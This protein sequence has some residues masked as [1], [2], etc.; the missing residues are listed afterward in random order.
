MFHSLVTKIVDKLKEAKFSDIHRKQQSITKLFPAH[1]GRVEKVGHMGGVR[2]K[3]VLSETWKFSV[4]S[5][6]KK[7]VW[8]DG[9]IHWLN[10]LPTLEKLVKDH[11]LWNIEGTRVDLRLL[12]GAFRNDCEVQIECNCPCQQYWGFN[13]ILSTDR[14]KAKYGDRETRSP[15]KRN[16]HQY[17]AMCKHLEAL[18]KTMPF[19]NSTIARWLNDFYGKD[20]E[21]IEAKARTEAEKFKKAGEELGK[22]S[23]PKKEQPKEAP[24]VEPEKPESK[25]TAPE[26]EEE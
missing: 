23:Q 24:K 14:Y 3:K 20:I 7:S 6:T 19:Y 22:K 10:I 5:G 13:Y 16:P 15:S 17:G 18:F 2:I 26:P 25:E 21:D 1:P 4:H 11:R 9:V 12:A 8:Y